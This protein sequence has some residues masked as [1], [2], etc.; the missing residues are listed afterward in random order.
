[1]G[2]TLRV[3]FLLLPDLEIL[4]LAGPLQAFDEARRA[5]A[6]LRVH[7]C[8]P[9]PRLRT[10]QGLWLA[11]LEPLPE[12]AAGYL[13]VVPGLRFAAVES[14][15]APVL[16][17]LREAHEMGAQLASICTGAFVLGR[18]G[19]LKGRQC[20]THWSRVDDLQRRFPTARVLENRLF[21]HD[22]PVTTSAGIASG[23]D[24]AL[25]LL[26][27]RF[28]PLLVAAVAREM[29]VYL[30]RDGSHRQQSVYLDYRTHL[31]PGVHRV[32]DWLVANPAERAN[33]SDLA[34]LA[35]LSPRHLTRMFRQATGVSVQEFTMRLRLELAR[36]LLHDPGL[37]VDGVAARC[38][39]GSARQLRRLWREV[40][41]TS[42]GTERTHRVAVM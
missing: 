15:P 35:A 41:G 27:R 26:D 29:V 10:D 12:P 11:E 21:V 9:Q 17:W 31:H 13:V 7:L 6:D 16:A 1:M 3:T 25:A 42:P 22:G 18:A 30:R 40:Y 37:T 19:L 2:S 4:D 38:G 24:M 23:I 39:F 36:G 32:Q 20:T 5:G 8:S 33:L 28:G 34:R 14:V